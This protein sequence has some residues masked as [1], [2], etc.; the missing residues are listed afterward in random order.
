[1]RAMAQTRGDD[2]EGLCAALDANTEA[3]FGGPWGA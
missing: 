2:L 1:V 3:A